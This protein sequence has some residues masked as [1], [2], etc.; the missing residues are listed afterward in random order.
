MRVS[1]SCRR[2]LIVTIPEETLLGAATRM[3]RYDVTALPVYRRH[4]LPVVDGG[5]L[6]GV[7]SMRDLLAPVG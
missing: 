3:R 1:E 2:V 5:R 4:R 6:E 7:L